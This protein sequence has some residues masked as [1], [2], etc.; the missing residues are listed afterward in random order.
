VSQQ[1]NLFNP[2][3]LKKKRIFGAVPMVQALVAIL[4]GTLALAGYAQFRVGELARRAAAGKALVEQREARLVKVTA[5]F[6]PRQANPA[7]AEQLAR[8]ELLLKSLREADA[9]L[10]NGRL[11]NTDGYAEYFRAL[12]RQN[13]GGLWLTGVS[14]VGAGHDIGV[15]GRAMQAT[16]IPNYVARLNAEKIMRGKTFASLRIE[17]STLEPAPAAPAPPPVSAPLANLAGIGAAAAAAAAAAS[18]SA[19]V[20]APAPVVASAKLAP[21]VDFSLQS[22]EPEA[23]K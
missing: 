22:I 11:G 1:I 2:I 21:F 7:L 10:H 4:L 18:A 3:F 9:V 16:L 5:Q 15:Q 8:T 12:A 23:A 19:A 17:R 13:V 14:I 20:P 6:Q